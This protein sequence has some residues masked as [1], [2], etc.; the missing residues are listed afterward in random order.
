M[1]LGPSRCS[2]PTGM[3]QSKAVMMSS[4]MR[5]ESSWM[6]KNG[7]EKRRNKCALHVVDAPFMLQG[8]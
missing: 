3:L 6:K 4:M 8:S 1:S 5:P 2:R 7:A